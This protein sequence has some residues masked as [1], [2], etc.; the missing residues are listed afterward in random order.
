MRTAAAV[1]VAAIIINVV[2]AA[3]HIGLGKWGIKELPDDKAAMQ[4]LKTQAPG[5][6]MY[7]GKHGVL[8][9]I[10]ATPDMAD[11]TQNMGPML[12]NEAIDDLV[13]AFVL[14]L[15]LV[16][17]MPESVLGYAS[18]SG[19]IGLL[20][21]LSSFVRYW[22]WYGFTPGFVAV[23][24]INVIVGTFLAGLAIAAIMKGGK[25]KA[26]AAAA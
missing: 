8:L 9:A 12:R 14:V 21:A 10:N 22:I 24:V 15:L 16:Q 3:T 19:L 20:I 11:Q 17:V 1:I 23:D 2:G 7:Y 26:S 4:A 6:G 13:I 18:T 5:N 25:G